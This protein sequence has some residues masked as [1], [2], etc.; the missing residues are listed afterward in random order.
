MKTEYSKDD[1]SARSSASSVAV[2]VALYFDLSARFGFG[3]CQ[4]ANGQTYHHESLQKA[5]IERAAKLAK[6]G[7]DIGWHTFRHTYRS[8]LDEPTLQ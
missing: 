2:R 6:V 8:W 3:F 7:E 5:Q 4:S 1:V